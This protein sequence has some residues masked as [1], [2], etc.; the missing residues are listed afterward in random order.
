MIGQEE[1]GIGLADG[2]R[3]V[4]Q[5]ER[6]GQGRADQREAALGVLEVDV[7][8]GAVEERLEPCLSYE[9]RPITLHARGDVGEHSDDRDRST[10]AVVH[11]APEIL[12]PADAAVRVM[13]AVLEGIG[14]LGGH[15]VADRLCDTGQVLC[16]REEEVVRGARRDQVRR[17]L[18][19]DLFDGVADVFEPPRRIG[20]AAE[21]GARYVL[22]ERSKL[23]PAIALHHRL[24][25]LAAR[26]RLRCYGALHNARPSR[27]SERVDR[28]MSPARDDPC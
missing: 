8:R 4:A 23:R 3:G 16:H 14:L 6:R 21:Y 13:H 18:A 17:P 11:G 24:C 27:S 15:R 5:A 9:Q 10:V 22:D 26:L 20:R 2:L 1:V 19:R 25:S 28:L 12:D 7:V